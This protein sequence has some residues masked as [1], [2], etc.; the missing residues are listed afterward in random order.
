MRAH[1]AIA[2]TLAALPWCHADTRVLSK[3]RSMVAGGSSTSLVDAVAALKR[4]E[5]SCSA[6]GDGAAEARLLSHVRSG[7]EKLHSLLQAPPADVSKLEKARNKAEAKQ[8]AASSEL[9]DDEELVSKAEKA[10]R[11]AKLDKADAVVAK[12]Q[13]ALDEAKSVAALHEPRNPVLLPSLKAM[14]GQMSSALRKG[15]SIQVKSQAPMV[16]VIDDWLDAAALEA[17]KQLPAEFERALDPP[18]PSADS[19][20]PPVVRLPT[21]AT[22]L[23]MSNDYAGEAQKPA[24]CLPAE[25]EASHKTI[26]RTIDAAIARAKAAK[27]KGEDYCDATAG[28][29]EQAPPDWDAEEDG[30]WKGE[31]NTAADRYPNVTN[32]CGPLTPALD[33]ALV[34]SDSVYFTASAAAAVDI[35]DFVMSGALGLAFPMGTETMARNLLDGLQSRVDSEASQPED[36]DAE[37][38]GPWAA[39]MLEG[40]SAID[41]LAELVKGSTADASGL[42]DAYTFSSSPEMV[43]LR[44]GT[45]GAEAVH[46]V[47]DDFARAK[48][49]KATPML[50]AYLHVSD[51]QK[52]SGGELNVPA[53][54]VS[55]PPKLGRLILVETGMED[56]TC[57]PA[58][59]IA[60]SPLKPTGRDLLMMRKTYYGDRS[61]SRSEG[62]HEGPQRLTPKVK[63]DEAGCR[64]YEHVGAEKGDAVLPLRDVVKSRGCLAAGASGG[65]PAAADYVP[66]PPPPKKMK[67]KATPTPAAVEAEGPAA[68]AAPP[69]DGAPPPIAR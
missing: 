43:R 60:L 61:F 21:N 54:G 39:P 58:S 29:V 24:L 26:L 9:N 36:W 28:L 5:Q 55:V 10:E 17:L 38:D 30:E 13:K 49:T 12:A 64:R 31:F 56:G 53:I 46:H 16:V 62:N 32:G 14:H 69:S 47:C 4:A 2:F 15:A 40:R 67:K 45:K 65:C 8:R 6:D 59:A 57:D 25:S 35:I 52:G 48:G 22:D 7:Y 23:G 11:K 18:T 42:G 34:Q 68:P 63:C 44:A 51:A 66:P 41:L 3:V 27:A 33:T 1:V 19:Q 37:E 20:A 50:R